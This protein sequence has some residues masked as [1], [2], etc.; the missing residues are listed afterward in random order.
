MTDGTEDPLLQNYELG[1]FDVP[2][3][4]E[5]MWSH[6]RAKGAT[7]G[8]FT[9]EEN[10]ES[11]D[12]YRAAY[13]FG[14]RAIDTSGG[15]SPWAYLDVSKGAPNAPK[16]LIVAHTALH[17]NHLIWIAAKAT[18]I[19]LTRVYCTTTGGDFST[20][21]EVGHVGENVV[22]FIHAGLAATKKAAYWIAH[23]NVAGQLGA[24]Y[25]A[26]NQPGIAVEMGG[27]TLGSGA[28][29]L[30]ADADGNLWVGAGDYDSSPVRFASDGSVLITG[31]GNNSIDIGAISTVVKSPKLVPASTTFSGSLTVTLTSKTPGSQLFYT[32]DGSTPT[33]TNGTV[34]SNG[35]TI[36]I[37]ATTTLKAIG[38]KLGVLSTDGG[39]NAAS[40]MRVQTYTL[41][42]SA[43]PT[44]RR[45]T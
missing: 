17:T 44:I 45:A 10:I 5:Q 24:P 29:Q 7:K 33:P 23:E 39:G 14:V 1:A 28:T 2:G 21:T 4:G 20:A 35:A 30:N 37:T 18:D 34:V 27:L 19:N 41:D 13:R 15:T 6:L 31:T 26:A 42:G 8:T 32:T 43:C 40:N 12:T 9:E 16:A 38:V 36:I 11:F 22:V 25:P 3:T